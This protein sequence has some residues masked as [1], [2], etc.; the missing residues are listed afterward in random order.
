MFGVLRIPHQIFPLYSVK[1]WGQL[2]PDPSILAMKKHMGKAKRLDGPNRL[3]T[4]QRGEIIQRR[5][6][7]TITIEYLGYT[8][9]QL[10][11][12]TRTNRDRAKNEPTLLSARELSKREKGNSLAHTNAEEKYYEENKQAYLT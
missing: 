4:V 6:K 12:L 3:G 1:A 7:D 10:E 9:G 5:E 2:T 11:V 8:G